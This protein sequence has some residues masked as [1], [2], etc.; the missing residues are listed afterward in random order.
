MAGKKPEA[1]DCHSPD[2][3]SLLCPFCSRTFPAQY[4]VRHSHSLKQCGTK[5]LM[6]LYGYYNFK[7]HFEACQRKKE[8]ASG[9]I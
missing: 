8:A 3:K 2:G 5:Q 4:G 6:S 7:R 1:K 9:K